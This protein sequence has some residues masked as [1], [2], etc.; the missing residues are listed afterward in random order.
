MD[1]IQQ[2]SALIKPAWSPPGYVFGPVWTLLYIVIVVSFGAVFYKA[3]N[4]KLSWIIVLPF[5]LNLIFNFAFTPIQFGLQNNF[6]AAIDV[7]LVLGTLIW[8]LVVIWPHMRWVAY[9]NIPY[10]AW[11]AFATALQLTITYLNR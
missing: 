5:I 6:L 7:L 11:V 1:K 9:V 3:F 8:A 2:Y 4:G 10:L